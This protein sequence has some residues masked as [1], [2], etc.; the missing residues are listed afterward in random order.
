MN[1]AAAAL[2]NFTRT[3]FLARDGHY[4][5]A[6]LTVLRPRPSAIAGEDD[7]L[8]EDLH[9][10]SLTMGSVVGDGRFRCELSER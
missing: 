6:N 5:F 9:C 4:V 3:P 8:M 10:K 1:N 7:L 2:G